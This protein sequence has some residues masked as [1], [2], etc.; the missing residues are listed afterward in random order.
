VFQGQR[1]CLCRF[2]YSED[3]PPPQKGGVNGDLE[4][5]VAEAVYLLTYP[6]KGGLYTAMGESSA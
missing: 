3:D 5:T 6:H 1:P 4:V 2:R